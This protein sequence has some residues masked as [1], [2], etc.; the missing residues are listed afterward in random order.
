MTVLLVPTFRMA[1]LVPEVFNLKWPLNPTVVWLNV[2][3]E[4]SADI[5]IVSL[6][7]ALSGDALRF[8][9]MSE[10]LIPGM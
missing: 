3:V 2:E 7:H 4:V 6:S 8:N 10:T 9:S 1:P 5:R